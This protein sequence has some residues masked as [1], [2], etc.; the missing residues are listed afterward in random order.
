MDGAPDLDH[1]VVMFATIAIMF[2]RKDSRFGPDVWIG[3]PNRLLVVA[4]CGWLTVVARHVALEP[5]TIMK[6]R[7]SRY[8]SHARTQ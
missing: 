4:Y 8:T 6:P 7:I 5:A 1:L 3:W 2:Q